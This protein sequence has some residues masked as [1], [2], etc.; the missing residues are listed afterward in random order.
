[1]VYTAILTT[2]LSNIAVGGTPLPDDLAAKMVASKCISKNAFYIM[3][4]GGIVFGV[5]V[6][7]EMAYQ[8]APRWLAA[9]TDGSQR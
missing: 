9:R 2:P 4:N 7:N 6:G 1:M 3:R 5:L 8:G